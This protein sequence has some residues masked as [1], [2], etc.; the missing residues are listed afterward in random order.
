LTKIIRSVKYYLYC[1]FDSLENYHQSTLAFLPGFIKSHG[2]LL[3]TLPDI[4]CGV[5]Y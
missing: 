1:E 3:Y 4:A 2:K 5:C